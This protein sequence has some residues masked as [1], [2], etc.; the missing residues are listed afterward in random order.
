M[1]TRTSRLTLAGVLAMTGLPALAH[2]G[3]LIE[4]AGHSHWGALIALG[5]AVA[6]GLWA[7]KGRKKPESE[8]AEVEEEASDAEPQEA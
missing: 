5:G 2:T 1:T 7:A 6:I 4:T 8:E 3:H